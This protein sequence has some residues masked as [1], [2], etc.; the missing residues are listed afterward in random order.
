MQNQLGISCK[1]SSA[2]QRLAE[3][4]ANK[5][6]VMQ[7]LQADCLAGVWANNADRARGILEQGNVEGA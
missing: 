2:Q 1:V 7:E 5:L 4:D 6:S 3:A